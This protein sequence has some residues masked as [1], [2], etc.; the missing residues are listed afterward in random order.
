[1]P[2]CRQRSLAVSMGYAHDPNNAAVWETIERCIRKISE[3]GFIAGTLV[4]DVS[5]TKDVI[6]L[7]RALRRYG[8][9][10]FHHPGRRGL[11]QGR[12]A[13]RLVHRI[14]RWSGAGGPSNRFDGVLQDGRQFISLALY[15]AHRAADAQRHRPPVARYGDEDGERGGA[16][17]GGAHGDGVAEAPHLLD[18]PSHGRELRAARRIRFCAYSGSR[19][20]RGT[21]LRRL[22]EP[23]ESPHIMHTPVRRPLLKAKLALPPTPPMS[24][25]RPRLLELMSEALKRPLTLL[26]APAGFGKSTLLSGWA[27]EAVDRPAVAWL[28]LDEDDRDPARFFDYLLAALHSAGLD[29]ARTASVS[30]SG[31]GSPSPKDRMTSLLDDLAELNDPVVL[32]LDDYHAIDNPDLDAALAFLVE[33]T[34]E[35]LRVVVATREEPRLPLSRWRTRQWVTEIGIDQLRFTLD[36]AAAFLSKF[37]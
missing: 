11:S 14:L 16:R 3:H 29:V 21:H 26:C 8:V 19:H 23:G 33:H 34:P 27:N 25:S 5:R 36:E 31:A 20:C 30:L 24:L 22:A 10:A 6:A 13:R 2:I 18:F 4:T 9:I 28:G 35:Q 7:G 32:V 1:M 37:F 12:Q 17:H 15:F